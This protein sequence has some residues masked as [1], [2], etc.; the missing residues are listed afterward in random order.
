MAVSCFVALAAAMSNPDDVEVRN[1][2][3]FA[4]T[5]HHHRACLSWRGRLLLSRLFL[6]DLSSPL[7]R[8][9]VDEDLD[10]RFPVDRAPAEVGDVR[11]AGWDYRHSGWVWM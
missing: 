1:S 10:D 2:F 5:Y 11:V 6:T 4:A 7:F 8:R 3:M 9:R